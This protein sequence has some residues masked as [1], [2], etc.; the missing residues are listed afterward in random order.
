M[1]SRE[2]SWWNWSSKFGNG[3]P[4]RNA[5]GRSCKNKFISHKIPVKWS[6]ESIFYGIVEC[7]LCE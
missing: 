6:E 5:S 7:T 3:V 1:H 2:T 4:S